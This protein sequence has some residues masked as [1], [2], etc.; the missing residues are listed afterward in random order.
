MGEVE[1]DIDGNPQVCALRL[2]LGLANSDALQHAL[3]DVDRNALGEVEGYKL[4]EGE[5]NI[6]GNLVGCTLGRFSG[7]S[8]RRDAGQRARQG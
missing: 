5:G 1:G 6:E 4:R 2:L 8:R 3:G 7:T